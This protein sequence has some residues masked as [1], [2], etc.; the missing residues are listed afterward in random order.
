MVPFL[1]TRMGPVSEEME[2]VSILQA[3]RTQM[4]LTQ[5]GPTEHYSI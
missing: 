2:M 4:D 5:V 3:S 1:T